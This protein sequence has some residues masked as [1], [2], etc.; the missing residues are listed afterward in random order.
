MLLLKVKAC[1]RECEKQLSVKN[2][3]TEVMKR[4][5]LQAG[6]H[7][8]LQGCSVTTAHR[9]THTERQCWDLTCCAGTCCR[10]AGLR[11]LWVGRCECRRVEGAGAWPCVSSEPVHHPHNVKRRKV[12]LRCCSESHSGWMVGF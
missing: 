10:A 9:H 7:S 2:H 12:F 8:V 3:Q 4:G 6:M 5:E 11:T 1:V